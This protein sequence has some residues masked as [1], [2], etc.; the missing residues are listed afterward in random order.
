MNRQEQLPPTDPEQQ[1]EVAREQPFLSHL[2]ELRDRLLRIILVVG[3]I[4]LSLVWF[5]NDLYTMLARPLLAHLP[6]SSSMIATEVASPFLTPFKL[7][8]VLSIFLAIPVVL[9]QAWAFIAPGLYRHERRLVFPL[10]VSSTLLFYAGM[11]FAYYVVMPLVFAF[12]TSTAPEGVAVM[13]DISRYLDFVLK[14]FFAFGV[15]FEVPVATVLLVLT[16]AITPEKLTGMR[17]YI[18]V[19]AFVIGMLLTPPDVISQTLLAVPMWFLFEAGLF[20]SRI[21][22]RRRKAA[23]EASAGDS[24]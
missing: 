1:D 13:T 23:M 21:M 14:M 18:I 24:G 22:L 15:A 6:E 9:Y 16:G 17:P 19:G 4:F 10:L 8:L 3:L 5:A 2:V 12:F 11:A 20:C 7:T